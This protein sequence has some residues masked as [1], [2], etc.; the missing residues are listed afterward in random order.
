MQEKSTAKMM[1]AE[2]LRINL[3]PSGYK[4]APDISGIL[5]FTSQGGHGLNFRA[6]KNISDFDIMILILY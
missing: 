5:M 6:C 2:N 1:A 3:K 4:K